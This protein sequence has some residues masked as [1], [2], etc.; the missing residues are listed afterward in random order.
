[1]RRFTRFVIILVGALGALSLSGYL[2]LT[3]T[4]RN[5]FEADLAMRARLAVV[6]A[7]QGL[8]LSP[9]ADAHR[10][11][12][13][14]A[15]ITR[16]KRIL[17]AAACTETGVPLGLTDAYPPEFPCGLMV[18]RARVSH[19]GVL[20]D[21]WSAEEHLLSG[22]V[23]LSVSRAQV[24]D[25]P[26]VAVVLVHDLAYLER[27]ETTTRNMLVTA[28]FILA[29]LAA[30]ITAFALR[31]VWRRWTQ[32]L[33]GALKGEPHEDFLPVL[34]DVRA[35]ADQLASE[36]AR[37]SRGGLWSPERLRA[38][39]TEHLGGERIV[40]LAN[41]EP[42]IHERGESGIRVV[43]PASGL[44]TAL[45]P[46]LRACSG[47]WVAHGGGSADRET[48]DANDRVMVPPG[49]ESYCIR[50]VWLTEAEE[51]G[52]YYGFSNEGLW[53]LCHVAH[54]RPQFRAEDWEKYVIVNRR[55][56]DAV[57]AEV[58]SE[59][60]IILVQDYHFALAPAMIRARLPRAT[61]ITFWH[62]PWPNAELI[63]ICPWH[64]ELIAGLLGS[65]IVGFQTQ[66]HCNN[67]IDTVDAYL[68][69]RIDRE[70]RAIVQGERRTLVRPY[71]IS[72]EWPV[73]WLATT[74]PVAGCRARVRRELGIEPDVMIGIGVDRLDY[75]KGIEERLRAVD[76][77]LKLHPEY[78]RRFTFVQLAAPSRT[79]IERYQ[80]LNERLEHLVAEINDRW[81]S[82]GY[83]PV[84]FLRSHHEPATVFRHYRAADLCYVSSLHDGMNLVAK[85][86]VAAREDESGVLILSQ[87]TGAA[88]D[89]TGALIV[90]PYD[91]HQ[92]AEAMAAA[93]RMPAV[94]QRERM[95]AMRRMVSEFN[96]Y[97]W[98]GRMLVDAAE[99]RRRER[100]SANIS[101]TGRDPG[102]FPQ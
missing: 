21:F 83:Q 101:R 35:L 88:R 33:R 48:V 75:T 76:L 43:H 74:P 24:G 79:K 22:P 45:E 31:T 71:P 90:N 94:E 2:V 44:V 69:S 86:F 80:A 28:F 81:S 84:V 72:I 87:F 96:V 92:A 89:L 93:L 73:G 62:I 54:A 65:S 63:G 42:Y 77:L 39:L 26:P 85:E 14:L 56:A 51:D 102:R 100:L 46:V 5:W 34:R 98:A 10:L 27:R 70:N 59:E 41:R 82:P 12:A 66:Q 19:D 16:D 53:P 13:T 97:R 7:R 64:E 99:V 37:E 8:A 29:I 36:Q 4:L 49:E 20:P 50:R 32:A 38:A 6:S 40:I 25:T 47:T 15:D 23:H 11:Q 60:P 17:A 95:H 68:E 1:M 91:L 30:A 67:F 55:F 57:C 18:A 58:D 61:I 52:Y 78:R 9:G 3:S